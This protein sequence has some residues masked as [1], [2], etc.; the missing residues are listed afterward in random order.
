[1]QT[2]IIDTSFEP[3]TNTYSKEKIY[4]EL[5]QNNSQYVLQTSSKQ[6]VL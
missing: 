1:M 4:L 6:F 3:R 5:L 2:N